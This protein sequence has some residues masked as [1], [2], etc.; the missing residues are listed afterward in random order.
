MKK[1]TKSSR[2]RQPRSKRSKREAAKS[3]VQGVLH[4]REMIREVL[5]GKIRDAVTETAGCWRRA[6]FSRG[7]LGSVLKV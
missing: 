6:M 5:M 7:E 3:P 4:F 1:S 2:R